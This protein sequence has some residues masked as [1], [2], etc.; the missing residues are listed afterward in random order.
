MS[1]KQFLSENTFFLDHKQDRR[2]EDWY[3]MNIKK[4]SF[5]HFTPKERVDEIIKSNKLML[6]PPYGNF[7]II[8]VAAISTI[9]GKFVPKVQTT[10]LKTKMEDLS[11]ILFKTSV[12]P[13]IGYIEEVLWHEDVIFDSVKI[14][15]VEDA[16]EMLSNSPVKIKDDAKVVYKEQL[17]SEY[18][19]IN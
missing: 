8:A 18:T 16:V 5:I 12:K 19:G 17:F 11:A 4:D 1:F 15:S 10:H 3:L 9:Y 2:G 14:V 6:N 13:D 7:G